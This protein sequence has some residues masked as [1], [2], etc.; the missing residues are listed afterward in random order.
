VNI[1][2]RNTYSVPGSSDRKRRS[3]LEDLL[4]AHGLWDKVSNFYGPRLVKLYEE[5]SLPRELA[6]QVKEFL[7]PTVSESVRISKTKTY[8]ENFEQ[9]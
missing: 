3:A 7:T 2:R 5:G 9:H 4:R 6:A 1:Y 8:D